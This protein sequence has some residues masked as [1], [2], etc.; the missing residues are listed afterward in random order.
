VQIFTGVILVFVLG[1]GTPETM[2]D[3]I[4]SNYWRF[5]MFVPI[6]IAV[7]QSVLLLFVFKYETP[8]FSIVSKNN[9][10]EAKLLLSKITPS[11]LK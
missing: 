7:L 2:E 3:K 5:M 8:I 9:E 11:N 1:L 4:N 6:L 10:E